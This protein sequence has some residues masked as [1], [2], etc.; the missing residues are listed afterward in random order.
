MWRA[1]QTR[2]PPAS[3]LHPLAPPP[4]SAGERECSSYNTR[5]RRTRRGRRAG[6]PTR[7]RLGAAAAEQLVIQ[8]AIHQLLHRLGGELLG[9]TS[10]V[11]LGEL[12][13]EAGE[14]GRNKDSEVLVAGLLGDFG[15][16]NDS[17]LDLLMVS[18]RESRL[19]SRAVPSRRPT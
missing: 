5:S 16:C 19:T 9:G 8:V 13:K 4:R 7:S 12:V 11:I 1:E 14:L 18:S 10:Q 15:W 3:A 6:R 17:H 2:P